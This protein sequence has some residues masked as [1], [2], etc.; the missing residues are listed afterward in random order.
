MNDDIKIYNKGHCKYLFKEPQE[1]EEKM[2][3]KTKAG[4]NTTI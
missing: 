4:T 3:A 2:R 1:F